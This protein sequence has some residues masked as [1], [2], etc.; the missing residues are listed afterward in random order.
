MDDHVELHDIR[1]DRR[2][3]IHAVSGAHHLAFDMKDDGVAVM[4]GQAG[5]ETGRAALAAGCQ[6]SVDC[7]RVGA[8]LGDMR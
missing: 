4:G 5:L 8:G 7:R 3:D 2:A 1:I 6:Y